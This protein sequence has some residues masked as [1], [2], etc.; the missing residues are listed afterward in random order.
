MPRGRGGLCISLEALDF[1]VLLTACL[2]YD[3]MQEHT[4][5]LADSIWLVPTMKTSPAET[6]ACNLV[7]S[8]FAA[9]VCPTCSSRTATRA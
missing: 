7:S 8:V 6:A 1:I 5:M 2:G 9:P 4:D 3:F